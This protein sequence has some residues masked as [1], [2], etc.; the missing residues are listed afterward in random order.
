[1]CVCVCVHL[2]GWYS[3]SVELFL[4]CGQN[5][6]RPRF[7]PSCYRSVTNSENGRKVEITNRPLNV[8]EQNK[9]ITEYPNMIISTNLWANPGIVW[10]RWYKLKVLPFSVLTGTLIPNDIDWDSST[11]YVYICVCA[12]ARACVCL[13]VRLCVCRQT[14]RHIFPLLCQSCFKT[15]LFR[16]LFIEIDV[17]RYIMKGD[18]YNRSS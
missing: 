6:A 16:E 3:C 4:F 9:Y 5:I 15:Y 12:G 2:N 7:E 14:N 8:I 1:M 18:V 13:C 17:D 11:Y 10:P